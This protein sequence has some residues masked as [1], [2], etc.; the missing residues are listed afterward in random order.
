MYF[1]FLYGSDGINLK[2]IVPGTFYYRI[3]SIIIHPY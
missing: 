3:T 1:K 2:L